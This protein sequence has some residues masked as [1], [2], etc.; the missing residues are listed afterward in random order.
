MIDWI[1]EAKKIQDEIKENRAHIHKYPELGNREFGTAAFIEER[2]RFYGISTKRLLDTAVI[3]YLVN[4]ENAPTVALRSDIDALPIT[5]KTAC[6]FSSLNK[7][8]MH[9]CGHDVHVSAA[10]GAARILSQHKDELKGNVRFIFQPD[11][12]S[13]GGAKRLIS[14]GV[15]DKVNAIFGM[16]VSPDLEFGDIG[17]RYGKFYAASTKFIINIIGKAAHG[18]EPHKGVD[19]LLAAARLVV[20]LKKIPAELKPEKTILNIGIFESGTAENIISGEAFLSGMIRTFGDENTAYMKRRISEETDKECLF[21]KTKGDLDLIDGYSGIINTDHET[22][23]A[24]NALKSML[25]AG[26]IKIIREPTLL[27]EDF[28][29]YIDASCGSYYH[30]GV[31]GDYGVHSPYFLPPLNAPV[32]GAAVHAR[33][34]SEY[35]NSIV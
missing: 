32:L 5:E 28:G 7:G 10:L 24:E 21:S 17:I 19:A 18:A 35:L 11:E 26:H 12:E 13:M 33:V 25:G 31:G 2:L 29:F 1:M 23:I 16:H 14:L 22:E 8:Y 30:L 20:S 3:G 34:V 15:M 4:D 27:S 6:A 9:A